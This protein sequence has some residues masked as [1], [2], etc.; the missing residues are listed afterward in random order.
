[1]K[2]I[3]YLLTS[4]SIISCSSKSNWTCEGDC[5]NGN[6]IKYWNSGGSDSGTWVNG[7]LNGFGY[8]I[9]GKTEF[10]GDTYRGEFQNNEYSGFGIYGDVDLGTTYTGEWLNGVPNGTGKMLF[11]EN[12]EFPGR[13]Y[14]GEWLDFKK[15]GHGTFFWGEAGKYTNDMY[16]GEWK[17]DE[18]HGAG[19][20]TSSNN[21]FEGIWIDGYCK[22]LA[23]S[24]YGE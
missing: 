20:F 13:Y 1:M 24:L 23:D 21:T 18:Q 9:Q 4:I 16:E 11:G 6:G 12:S 7:K 22:E 3:F 19:K 17:E 8:Q 14:D 2:I 10:L 15:H 5:L